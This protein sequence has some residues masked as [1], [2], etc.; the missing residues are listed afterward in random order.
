MNRKDIGQLPTSIRNKLRDYCKERL[1]KAEATRQSAATS[2]VVSTDEVQ[3]SV[4]LMAQGEI[5]AFTEMY[6]WFK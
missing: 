6:N 2:F 5:E 4:A 3:R 1:E